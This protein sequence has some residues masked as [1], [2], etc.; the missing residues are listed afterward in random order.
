M[1]I[2]GSVL[3]PNGKFLFPVPILNRRF[4]K[5]NSKKRKSFKK[6]SLRKKKISKKIE[7]YNS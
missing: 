6:K 5:I 3:K 2:Q 7:R 4:S 1:F